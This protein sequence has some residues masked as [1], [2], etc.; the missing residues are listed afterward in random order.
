MIIIIII[1]IIIKAL[2]ILK[3]LISEFNIKTLVWTGDQYM[4]YD[5]QIKSKIKDY[6]GKYIQKPIHNICVVIAKTLLLLLFFNKLTNLINCSFLM[7]IVSSFKLKTYFKGHFQN[8][9]C[10]FWRIFLRLFLCVCLRSGLLWD[11]K[12]PK[13]A[14]RP[15]SP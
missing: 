5:L 7:T 4:N 15:K 6:Y 8:F 3:K 12:S 10:P 1:I 9:Q 13:V 11:L 14:S 2:F